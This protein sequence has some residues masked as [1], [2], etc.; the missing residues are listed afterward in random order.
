LGSRAAFFERVFVLLA[1]LAIFVFF[2]LKIRLWS[3]DL[4]SFFFRTQRWENLIYL[5]LFVSV[6]GF[7]LMR[8]TQGFFSRN[9]L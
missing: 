2:S 4:I 7:V 6:V 9:R 1:V 5:F 3:A 8:L